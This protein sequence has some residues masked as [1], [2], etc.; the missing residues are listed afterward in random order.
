MLFQVPVE[1][2]ESST[3]RLEQDALARR[4]MQK[5]L[6]R[7]EFEEDAMCRLQVTKTDKKG[8]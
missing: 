8:N 7:E 1:L 4:I 2:R 5:E 3:S 6:A